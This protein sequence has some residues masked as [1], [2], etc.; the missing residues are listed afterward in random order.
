MFSQIH[1]AT[2]PR[3][4]SLEGGSQDLIPGFW[5]QSLCLLLCTKTQHTMGGQKNF[6]VVP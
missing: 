4:C 3:P 2:W 5:L 1:K 6:T